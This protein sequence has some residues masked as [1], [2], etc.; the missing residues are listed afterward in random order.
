VRVP[1]DWFSIEDGTRYRLGAGE[2]GSTNGSGVV[3]KEGK[4]A[5]I[6]H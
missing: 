3:S 5:Q 2:K 6:L 1:F 4:K